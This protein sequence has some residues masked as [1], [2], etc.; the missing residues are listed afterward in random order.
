MNLLKLIKRVLL[1]R[2]IPHAHAK[3]VRDGALVYGKMK[4]P[5]PGWTETVSMVEVLGIID[6]H[7]EKADAVIAV[8]FRSADSLKIAIALATG[9]A[10]DDLREHFIQETAPA[11]TAKGGEER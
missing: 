1:G 4:W 5:P 2:N 11:I 7:I 8:A 6:R 3:L 10:L 9:I